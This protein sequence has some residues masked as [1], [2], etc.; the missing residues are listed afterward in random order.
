MNSYVPKAVLP[1][2]KPKTPLLGSHTLLPGILFISFLHIP[3]IQLKLESIHLYIQ[4]SFPKQYLRSV[5]QSL[6]PEPIKFCNFICNRSTVGFFPV[7][8]L[9][10]TIRIMRKQIIVTQHKIIYTIKVGFFIS[11]FM[12]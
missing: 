1:N 12:I 6:R 5:A 3:L 2:R 4:S 7:F 8:L 10:N 11:T 9:Y